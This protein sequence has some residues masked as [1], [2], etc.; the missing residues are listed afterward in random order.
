MKASHLLMVLLACAAIASA[1]LI[2]TPDGEADKEVTSMETNEPMTVNSFSWDVFDS[3]KE[4]EI[5]YSPLGLYTAL[6]MLLN[7]AEPGSMTE[8]ELLD[9]LH[10][11][12][13]KTVNSDIVKILDSLKADSKY[14][15]SSSNLILVDKTY[16]SGRTIN[17]P[18][19]ETIEKMFKGSVQTADIKDGTDNVK[20]MIREWVSNSTC[21]FIPDYRS[22]LDSST[23][24]DV[25]NVVYFKGQW[26]FEF[27]NKFTGKFRCSDGTRSD[28]SMMQR[29]FSSGAIG[30]HTDGKYR[31]IALPYESDG[32]D[33]VSMIFILPADGGT[34]I[35][36]KWSSESAEYREQFI[37][38]VR[39]GSPDSMRLNVI[40]PK[41]DVDTSYDL[42]ELFTS[43]G[44]SVSMSDAA[45]FTRII[46]GDCLKITD[47]KHQAKLKVD[48][49]GTEAAAITEIVIKNT[50]VLNIEPVI[51]FHCDIPF[52]FTISEN[53]YGVDL[54]TGYIGN[55]KSNVD[56]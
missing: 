5:F 36:S 21:G 46:N 29:T 51:D 47:G 34:D 42:K 40:I 49:T 17:A 9:A 16:V 20:E 25:L 18:F 39:T 12:G 35:K 45:E 11:E 19:S 22:I 32:G 41:L 28:V 48:E 54:F 56:T 38:N 53:Q 10:K 26:V 13:C 2:M 30:Y 24:T 33:S 7:G 6:A 14:R 8:R 31:G 1:A 43:L 50:S 44:L 55:L 52:I 27:E 37:E 3:L 4:D 23:L 15:F